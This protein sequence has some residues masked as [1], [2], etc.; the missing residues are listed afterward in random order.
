MQKGGDPVKKTAS[1]ST[2]ITESS[3]FVLHGSSVRCS[4]DISRNL[5]LAN[6]DAGQISQVIQNLVINAQQAMPDGGEIKISCENAY[7]K[8]SKRKEHS[9][10]K[11]FVKIAIRDFGAGIA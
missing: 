2:V 8:H 6:I 4:F 9:G 1:V 3:N 5:W 7:F 10:S 11:K